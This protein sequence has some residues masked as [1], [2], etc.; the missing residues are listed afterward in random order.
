MQRW[1]EAAVDVAALRQ[2]FLAH[3]CVPEGKWL[4]RGFEYVVLLPANLK[5]L[6]DW[7]PR[8]LESIEEAA[9]LQ[10]ITAAEWFANQRKESTCQK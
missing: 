2:W 6:D 7:K 4:R 3:G 10:G 1:Q 9:N 8:L 5:E